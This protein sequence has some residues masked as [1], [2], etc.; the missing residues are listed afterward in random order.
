MRTLSIE[1][2]SRIEELDRK[3]MSA[4]RVGLFT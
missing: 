3:T 2:L 4:L 1:D